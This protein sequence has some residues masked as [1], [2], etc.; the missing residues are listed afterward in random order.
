MAR[1]LSRIS[2]CLRSHVFISAVILAG[3]TS[4]SV[5]GNEGRANFTALTGVLRCQLSSG[6]W[7]GLYRDQVEVATKPAPR[8]D[9]DC[10]KDCSGVGVCDYDTG[11]C[12]CPAGYGGE[13]CSAPRTRPCWRMGPDHRDLGWLEHKDWSHSRCAGYCDTDIAMCYCPP[14]TKYGHVPAPEGSP[15]GTPPVKQG[16][17]LYMCHPK[18]DQYNQTTGWGQVPYED[19]FGKHGWCNAEASAFTCPCRL[20][21]IVGQ[22]CNIKVE[23]NC[24]NQCTGHGECKLGFCKC[25]P[26]WYGIDCSRKR[27]GLPLE[28][29]DGELKSPWL[30]TVIKQVLAAADPPVHLTRK[31]PFI[32][33]YD[34]WPEFNT[35]VQQYKIERD[36]CSYR[37]WVHG[38]RSEW[39]GYNAYAVESVL[40]DLFST[41]EHRT[42]DPEEADYFFVP[43]MAG[44]LYDVYGWNKI[45]MW[46][47]QY[48]GTRPFGSANLLL[49]TQKWLS[50]KY[51]WFNRS[52]GQDHIWVMPH[53]EGACGAPKQIW[54]GII[55]SHWGRLDF[56]HSS[57]TQYGADNYSLD[58]HHPTFPGGWLAHSVKTHPCFDPNKDLVIPCFKDPRHFQQSGYMGMKSTSTRD[59]FLFFR[60][61]VGRTRDDPKCMY[62]RCIRQTIDRLVKKEGWKEKYNVWYGDRQDTPGEYGELLSRS[63]FCLAL[64]GDGWSARFEDGILHG[65]IPVIIMDNV[66]VPFESILNVEAFTV[67]ILQKDIPHMMEILGGIPEER[68]EEMQRNVHKVWHRF[69]YMGLKMIETE[70][71]TILKR[72]AINAGGTL[73]KNEG[74]E[75]ADSAVDD[76]FS[77]IIQ[78][79]YWRIPFTRGKH[80]PNETLFLPAT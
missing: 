79:L 69:R 75:K 49:E 56:P 63:K 54:L 59:I 12:Y 15:L 41:S 45:P 18:T 32:Y 29:G 51:P 17:P 67:R 50:Q 42:F 6:E 71:D 22:Y 35:D 33:V 73:P 11:T 19:M 23:M 31:R 78:W 46:P 16:R 24:A 10:P 30:K 25:H 72:N 77:T 36:H 27:K 74:V 52:K 7:C 4:S 60:G 26:G 64:P 2:I 76:A 39:I 44:C 70:V 61:D 21:G 14:E 55:L 47:P 5:F 38:N 20:D 68:V 65:C 48:H 3:H 53:D 9:V 43:T 57:N 37:N 34:T 80:R 28:P 8:G 58:F 62:S 1:T 13:D 40:I 66:Q